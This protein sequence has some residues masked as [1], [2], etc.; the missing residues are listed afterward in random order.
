VF[1]Q[2]HSHS[3]FHVGVT[4]SRTAKQ[5]YEFMSGMLFTAKGDKRQ[6]KSEVILQE[7]CTEFSSAFTQLC[8]LRIEILL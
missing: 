2:Q 5:E 4:S 8:P 7:T 6:C 1:V 3:F